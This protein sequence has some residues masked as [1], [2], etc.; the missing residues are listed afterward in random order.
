MPVASSPLAIHSPELSAACP[1]SP[2]PV[3]NLSSLLPGDRDLWLAECLPSV[4]ESFRRERL[5]EVCISR[6][7]WVYLWERNPCKGWGTGKER[8][9][10]QGEEHRRNR[11]VSTLLFTPSWSSALERGPLGW[12]NILFIWGIR[13][14]NMFLSSQLLKRTGQENLVPW[15]L[16][17]AGA[18]CH[19]R[20]GGAFP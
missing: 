4:S 3:P 8:L 2:V 1:A 19:Q 13:R 9:Q 17:G 16:A 15:C 5:L 20:L 10:L 7:D 14:K 6:R 12:G 11:C 18:W